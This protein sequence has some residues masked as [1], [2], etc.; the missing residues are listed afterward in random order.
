MI[1]SACLA[2]MPCR[3]DGA[4]RPD[5]EIVRA[6]A[7]GRAV[8]ACAEQ[9]G[10]LPTPRP[11]AEIVGGDGAD[12]LDGVARVLTDTGEDV[13]AE[14]VSGAEAV[15]SIAR[16][17]G[18]SAAVLQARSP[19]CGCGEI[20]DGS[21]SGT[22]VSGDGVLAALLKREGITVRPVRGQRPDA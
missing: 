8:V 12:V 10:G 15:A 4:A 17:N 7:E 6:V 11:P 16:S 5:A 19:S 14:F 1:V 13:T 21:H 3:Y 9:L 18:A 20:Y 22:R 2:G